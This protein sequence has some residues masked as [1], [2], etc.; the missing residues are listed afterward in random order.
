MRISFEIMVFLAFQLPR[1]SG[2]NPTESSCSRGMI[3]C[4]FGSEG[5]ARVHLEEIKGACSQHKKDLNLSGGW[6]I[7]CRKNPGEIGEG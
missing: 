2:D 7:L 4:G 5:N 6:L 1:G 3:R